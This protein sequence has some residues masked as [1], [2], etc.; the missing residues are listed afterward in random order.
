[1]AW[2]TEKTKQLLLDA[3]LREF[4]TYGLAGARVDRIAE[5]A[6]VNKERIYQYFGKKDEFFDVVVSHALARLMQEVPVEGTGPAA[7]GEY[8]GRVFDRHVEDA[9]LARLL[10]WEGLERGGAPVGD[11]ERAQRHRLK[12]DLVGRVLPGISRDDAGELLMTIFSLCDAWV[13]LPQLDALLVRRSE[14]RAA[15]RR[16]SIVE[17]VVLLANTMSERSATRTHA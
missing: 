9:S 15:A 4:C 5:R 3:G 10:F 13:V 16:A 14:G 11:E 6:G 17:T 12:V 2:D 7:L 8:A 1:M